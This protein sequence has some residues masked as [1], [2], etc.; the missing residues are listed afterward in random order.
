[1]QTRK[2]LKALSKGEID[3]EGKIGP[4]A[5]H[6]DRLIKR[7]EDNQ[8]N[9]KTAQN[10]H[11]V[12]AAMP[13]LEAARAK[14]SKALGDS[15]LPDD[16]YIVSRFDAFS[17]LKS[18][19][20]KDLSDQGLRNMSLHVERLWHKDPLGAFTVGTLSNLRNH[21]QQSF[22]RSR[23][24]EVIDTDIPKVSFNTLPIANL[25]RVASQ[26]SSQ[27]DYNVAIA[28]HGIG[29]DDPK[30]VRARIFIRA[31][32]NH[33]EA[34]DEELWKQQVEENPE[35][36]KELNK[37]EDRPLPGE[38]GGA[39]QMGL[40][41]PGYKASRVRG[42]DIAARVAA[43][44]N[45]TAQA[46]ET[47]DEWAKFIPF[48]TEGVKRMSEGYQKMVGSFR[49]MSLQMIMQDE[50]G[51]DLIAAVA[52]SA[53]PDTKMILFKA[54]E[55]SGYVS[56]ESAEKEKIEV[57]DLGVDGTGMLPVS[58]GLQ[59]AAS[60]G[61]GFK[62]KAQDSDKEGVMPSDQPIEFSTPGT[63]SQQDYKFM[64]DA[65]VAYSKHPEIAA[66]LNQ[67]G[68]DATSP[69]ATQ[70]LYTRLSEDVESVYP[71]LQK[72]EAISNQMEMDEMKGK[73]SQYMVAR[74]IA[75]KEGQFDVPG[76]YQE[77]E[78]MQSATDAVQYAQS[79]PQVAELVQKMGI[80]VR[81]PDAV[82][83]IRNMVSQ[84]PE[85]GSILQQIDQL[86]GQQ[87]MQEEKAATKAA[88][89]QVL[90]L[91]EDTDLEEWE[92]I[93]GDDIES[94]EDNEDE[95]AA[96]LAKEKDLSEE[97]G[98]TEEL[99]VGGLVEEGE[100]EDTEGDLPEEEVD[101]AAGQVGEQLG[102][103]MS[104]LMPNLFARGAKENKKAP[105]E[106][107]VN[108]QQPDQLSVPDGILK[109]ETKLTQKRPSVKAAISSKNS[110]VDDNLDHLPI[111]TP[112][113]ARVSVN[114]VNSLQEVPA[115][116]LGTVDELKYA[117]MRSVQQK[118]A[119]IP[120]AFKKNIKKK[121]GDDDEDGGNPFGKDDGPPSKD[122]DKGK[123]NLE[124]LKKKK[125]EIEGIILS[126]KNYKLAGYEI[127]VDVNHVSVN[128]K[129]GFKQYQLLDM[130]S[131]LDDFIYLAGTSNIPE[132]N[133]SPMF[134]IREGIRLT[135][136]GCYSVNSYNMPK[137]ASDLGC[138][139]CDSV[140]PSKIVLAAFENGV[141]QEESVLVAYSPKSK[142]VE[143]GDVFARAA[144]KISADVIDTI[145]NCV[146]AHTINASI[147]SKSEAWDILVQAGFKPIAQEL[148]IEDISLP[149]EGSDLSLPEMG[150]DVTSPNGSDI[151]DYTTIFEG[152]KAEQVDKTWEE[153]VIEYGSK[154]KDEIT[155]GEISLDD[156]IT[157]AKSIF[158]SD[159]MAGG[160][161]AVMATLERIAGDIPSTNVNTQQPD[162][163]SIAK[164]ILGPDSD[165]HG[166]L[167]TPGKPKSQVKPQGTFSNTK[168][169]SESDSRDPGDFGAG[170]PK[171][172]HVD[173]DQQGV[174]KSQVD[175][176]R[177]SDNE[178]GKLMR[179]FDSKSKAAP[180]VMQS[181]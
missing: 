180:Q 62:L 17:V 4:L 159:D 89:R 52:V 144:N 175:L 126:G 147:K 163:E 51:Q 105:M 8:V 176:G 133:F 140:I 74:K 122:K 128:S 119:E 25:V 82:D 86:I 43:R 30:H 10:R 149:E 27:E 24:A 90:A 91:F 168:I 33:K 162:A 66:L 12:A 153:A 69:N 37:L 73:P 127:L 143:L 99:E 68:V 34:M 129:Q 94:N 154:A 108:P 31:L 85:Y 40:T 58:A 18:A 177:D 15:I 142:Q 166:D 112:E 50:Y 93:S 169:D 49:G 48:P 115:W 170:K 41:E 28:R 132:D 171:P 134:Y 110:M 109:K 42:S 29:G 3:Y 83:Q 116:W 2:A 88:F 125:G 14:A 107:K 114:W 101:E 87:V 104:E 63:P 141:A 19:S 95:D 57:A 71:I 164:G 47:A 56:K 123:G 102:D 103:L 130:D 44:I 53:D 97:G 21:Y 100:A 174:S 45:K 46:V 138:G 39:K 98:L 150:I 36:F 59:K 23:V 16:T 78:V 80:D 117:A 179:D 135:C 136:P 7:Y 81:L 161:P 5:K 9:V 111:H 1:M 26:I 20:K 156:V 38:P 65:A 172:Q 6:A 61:A 137:E 96:F 167:K 148:D 173:T 146:E 178:M 60:T 131:A 76:V 77:E 79:N 84:N 155:S 92:D 106:P 145:G 120:E 35:K 67:L 113:L 139:S 70:D 165:T 151:K 75:Q 160:L 124:N 54:L 152:W 118:I 32:L 55:D 157:S 11:S 158:T 72:I 13:V 121:K 22:S 181:K 64:V